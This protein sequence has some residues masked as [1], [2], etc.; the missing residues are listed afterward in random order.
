MKKIIIIITGLLI[1]STIIYII[2]TS[3]IEGNTKNGIYIVMLNNNG[4][5]N[6][7]KKLGNHI[8]EISSFS[9][10]GQKVQVNYSSNKLI[11]TSFNSP[12]EASDEI[13]YKNYINSQLSN[14]IDVKNNVNNAESNMLI[15][16]FINLINNH[17]GEEN[18]NA[19][20]I[21]NF[22]DCYSKKDA[23][24]LK[25]L[26]LNKINKSKI[27]LVTIFWYVKTN[28]SEPEQIILKSLKQIGLKV[29]E[30]EITV[31]NRVCNE[32]LAIKPTKGY[33]NIDL[34]IFSTLDSNRKKN[35]KSR[36]EKM[37]FDYQKVKLTF[38]NS[39]TALTEEYTS[40]DYINLPKRIDDFINSSKKCEWDKTKY[41]LQ[42]ILENNSN[43]KDT[44]ATFL[45]GDA[46]YKEELIYRYDK[47]KPSK[48]YRMFIDLNPKEFESSITDSFIGKIE[49]E[50][51]K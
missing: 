30:S 11:D 48:K 51:I 32:I 23:E 34:A 13:K 37:I 50:S 39:Q 47:I 42:T 35:F 41:I 46:T 5:D 28:Q 2:S 1:L 7:T 36:V 8:Y 25:N 16:S 27:N 40:K 38:Y 15:E 31:Q 12:P 45:I 17:N 3:I 10:D 44:T 26:I 22:P 33:L 43:V 14:L 21:G 18:I 29:I 20:I 19:I 49:Y 9:N 24:F 4:V 6:Y